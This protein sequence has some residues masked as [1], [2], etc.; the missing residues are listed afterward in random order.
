MKVELALS[1]CGFAS[2]MGANVTVV[3][4]IAGWPSAHYVSIPRKW[5]S[6]RS[7]GCPVV[8]AHEMACPVYVL[9]TLPRLQCQEASLN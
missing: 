5:P 6:V 1:L 4:R 2:I 9:S 7:P 3:M 8:S